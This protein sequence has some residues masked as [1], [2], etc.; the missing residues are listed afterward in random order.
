MYYLFYLSC[1]KK[2]WH[3][4]C[5]NKGRISLH[6]WERLIYAYDNKH[7]ELHDIEI[8]FRYYWRYKCVDLYNG[9]NED[10]QLNIYLVTS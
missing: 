10:K 5:G 3:S 9:L 1:K 8:P 2:S 6:N 4:V 7:F